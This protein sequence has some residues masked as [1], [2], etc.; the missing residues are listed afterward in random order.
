MLH[1][2][3]CRPLQKSRSVMREEEREICLKKKREGGV[4]ID[5]VLADTTS[6]K[7]IDAR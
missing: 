2:F 7:C 4:E 5:L 6:R 3:F 1:G